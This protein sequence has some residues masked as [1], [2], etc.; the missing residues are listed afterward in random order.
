MNTLKCAECGHENEP[1][2]VYCHNCGGRIDRS[3]LVE[4]AQKNPK[5]VK[6]IRKGEFSGQLGGIVGSFF[7][8]A[9]FAFLAACLVQSIRP[10]AGVPAEKGELG[11]DIV[12]APSISMD[13]E[14][15]LAS[16]RRMDYS[17]AQLNVYLKNKLKPDKASP[18]PT[19]LKTFTKAYVNLQSGSIRITK[20]YELFTLPCYVGGSYIPSLVDGQ[21]Q[22][23]NVGANLGSLPLPT[24]LFEQ[25]DNLLFSDLAKGMKEEASAAGQMKVIQV[26]PK[27]V[28]II[29]G[30]K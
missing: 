2:R 18:I 13:L 8:T 12:N 26:T 1:Q 10:P 9:F 25:I 15:A 21:L 7:K 17:E 29:S 6:P 4:E 11:A 22:L 14:E 30:R 19:W 16:P 3:T 23:K 20:Q 27:A 5:P 24:L 28:T